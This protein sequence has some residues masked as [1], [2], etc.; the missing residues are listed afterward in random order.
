MFFIKIIKTKWSIVSVTND[1]PP[2]VYGLG[3]N[4]GDRVMIEAAYAS[5]EESQGN[6]TDTDADLVISKISFGF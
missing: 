2:M 3:Y 4:L 6:T 1:G 5:I